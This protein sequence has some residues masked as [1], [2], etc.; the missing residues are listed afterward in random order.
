MTTESDEGFATRVSP[1][2]PNTGGTAHKFP[3]HPFALND[4]DPTT[5][6]AAYGGMPPLP[7][8]FFG[9]KTHA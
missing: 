6:F 4:Y 7:A 9:L 5:L 8:K 1:K 2:T 3:V